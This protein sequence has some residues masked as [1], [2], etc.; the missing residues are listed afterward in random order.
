M[1]AA[2]ILAESRA[3]RFWFAGALVSSVSTIW[4]ANLHAHMH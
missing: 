4:A 3:A 1:P 2:T